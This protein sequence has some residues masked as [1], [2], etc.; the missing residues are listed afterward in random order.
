MTSSRASPNR[1]AKETPPSTRIEP[2]ENGGDERAVP[3]DTFIVLAF[4]ASFSELVI[5]A[6]NAQQ[7]AIGNR[8]EDLSYF[9]G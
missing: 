7:G 2:A 4:I 8:V 3:T 9:H 1:C 6:K 5:E